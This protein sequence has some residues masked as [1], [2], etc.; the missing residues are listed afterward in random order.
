MHE[1]GGGV[2][3]RDALEGA[4]KKIFGPLD[5]TALAR[6][7]DQ[8]EIVEVPGGAPLF[9]QGDPGDSLYIL[10]RGRLNVCV[11]DPE[12]DIETLV[13]ETAPG[14]SVGEIGLLTGETRTASL[15][16][17][18][19]S[20]LARIGRE[21]FDELAE[22]NPT[23]LRGLARVVVDLLQK[24]TSSHRYSPQVS[25]IAILPTRAKNGA[26]RFAKDLGAT[27][28]RA[29]S[30]LH[31]DS[32]HLDALVG[33]SGIGLASPGSLEGDPLGDWLAKQED[34]HRFLLLEADAEA[35]EWTQRCLRQADMILIVGN[36]TDDPAVAAA[37]LESIQD[38]ETVR[39]VRHV[40]VLL[41]PDPTRTISG[42]ARWLEARSI[43]EHHHVRVGVSADVERLGRVLSGTAIGLVLGGGGARG[44]AHAGVYR[45]LCE[46]DI[47]IDWV[48][49]S[50]IGAVFGAGIAMGWDPSRVEE[51]AR[52]SFVQERPFGDFTVPFVALLRGKR[53]DRLAQRSFTLDIEDMLLPYFCVSSDLTA[54]SLTV[55]ERGELWRAIRASVSL[56]GVLPP[57]VKSSH[58]SIDGG[59]LNNL[60][61]DIMLDRSVGSVIA[62]DLSARE[63]SELEYPE[64]PGLFQIILSRLPFMPKLR[65]PGIVTLMM[66]AT[67]MASAVHSRAVRSEAALLLNPPVGRFG[68]LAMNDFEEI[69]EVGY[70]HACEALKDWP[71]RLAEV[72]LEE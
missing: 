21:A 58:L 34:E 66:R 61:V 36:S 72:A 60:P 31:V 37:E 67:V 39:S 43:N 12:T 19:D 46:H 65:V 45:A 15:W 54:A 70:Q 23:L 18:R 42:T 13:G 4:C 24:R 6:L 2:L 62:V 38:T 69:V 26:A 68:L 30:T 8:L 28:E 11:R 20:R 64:I 33:I 16:A 40:L 51:E 57:A 49:G 1:A 22:S 48:G 52:L 71:P 32:E 41:H 29:G 50:S 14:E 7:L 44:F 25:C 56:P 47:P 17:T 10:L 3:D 55:H 27:L 59:I 53:I 9:R 35:T 63:E 5:D